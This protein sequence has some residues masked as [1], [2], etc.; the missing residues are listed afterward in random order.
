MKA[1]C[2]LAL[3]NGL[4]RYNRTRNTF[5]TFRYSTSTEETANRVIEIFEDS[6]KKLWVTA[7]AG[8]FE[9]DRNSGAIQ[10]L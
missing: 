2:G 8:T 6:R 1:H 10:I 4:A 3:D 9:F 5:T 7:A